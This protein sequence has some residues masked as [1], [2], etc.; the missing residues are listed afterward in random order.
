MGYAAEAATAVKD[1]WLK[2][3]LKEMTGFCLPTSEPS[4]AI[5]RKLGFEKGGEALMSG[6]VVVSAY[7]LPG[8]K[9]YTVESAQFN[10]MGVDK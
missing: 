3:G 4:N 7:V 2:F 10:W 8:M 1:Y 6:K 5:L 9:H